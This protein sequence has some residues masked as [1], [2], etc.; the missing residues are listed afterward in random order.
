MRASSTTVK[1]SPQVIFQTWMASLP[2]ATPPGESL[3]M[4]LSW[5][6]E[7][8]ENENGGEYDFQTVER[9]WLDEGGKPD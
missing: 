4:E 2:T 5:R 7:I 6:D 3:T 9:R 8:R 1:N